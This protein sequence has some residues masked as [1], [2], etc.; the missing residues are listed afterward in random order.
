MAVSDASA[1]LTDGA[2]GDPAGTSSRDG[3]STATLLDAVAFAAEKHRNQRRKDAEASPYINHPI[4]LAS[5]LK[6]QGIDD[7]VVLCAALL[8][9]TVEDTNTTPEELRRQ[10][11][12]AI[13]DVV[14]EVTD[15]TSLPKM[16]RKRLQIEHA[17]QRCRIA[18]NWSSWPTRSAICATWSPRRPRD[19]T[20]AASATILRGPRT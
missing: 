2:Q 14:L 8:H 20:C 19:G 11:G 12:N 7:I 5:L 4:Q 1:D 3:D 18:P 15:D 17:R 6:R 16:E 9:D 13:T 10:F